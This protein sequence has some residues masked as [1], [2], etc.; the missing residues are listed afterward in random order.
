MR[1]PTASPPPPHHHPHRRGPFSARAARPDHGVLRTRPGAADGGRDDTPGRRSSADPPAPG[2]PSLPSGPLEPR[3]RR[4]ARPVRRTAPPCF[5]EAPGR[6]QQQDEEDGE[7]AQQHHDLPCRPLFL[8]QG[9][10]QAEGPGDH[11]ARIH[12]SELSQLTHRF[13]RRPPEPHRHASPSRYPRHAASSHAIVADPATG[14]RCDPS[15]PEGGRCAVT[16]VPE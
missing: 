10:Q 15:L 12:G 13:H 2:L 6:P 5:P 4:V 7:Q 16:P 14:R 8:N 3:P 9:Q 1:D 11:T